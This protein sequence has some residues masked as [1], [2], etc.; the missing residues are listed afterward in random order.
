MV[1]RSFTLY[2]ANQFFIDPNILNC[3]ENLQALA[4]Q[5]NSYIAKLSQDHYLEIHFCERIEKGIELDISLKRIKEYVAYFWR[6]HLQKHFIEEEQLL[7]KSIDD[8][9]CVKGKEDHIAIIVEIENIISGKSNAQHHF[10]HLVSAIH[11]HIKFEERVLFPH[12]ELLLPKEKLQNIQ[13][14]LMKS[15]LDNLSDEFSDEFWLQDN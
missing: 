9:F 6:R 13:E 12:L 4:I 3:L 2:D 8:V 10:L 15:H 11:Q 7:F 1:Q 5:N 14:S